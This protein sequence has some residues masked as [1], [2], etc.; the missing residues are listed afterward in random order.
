MPDDPTDGQR[1]RSPGDRYGPF[2]HVHQV[3]P[4]LHVADASGAHTLHARDA[5]RSAGFE[6]E[7]FVDQVDAPLRKEVK[8]FAELDQFVVPD[9]TA[10]IYQLAVGST[11]V[12]SLLVR[13]EPLLLNYHNLTPASFF[14]K[15]APNWLDAVALGRS[16]L[17]RLAKRTSHAIAVSKFNE[18]DLRAAGFLSTSVVPPFVDVG[19]E[20]VSKA[21]PTNTDGDRSSRSG[22]G[23]TW[24]FVG[25]LLPHKAAHD[26]VRGLA[27]YREAYDPSA[28]LVLVGGHPVPSY[29]DAVRDYAGSLGLKDAVCMAGATSSEAL[30]EA[31]ASA[32]VFVCLS[33]HEG[34]C[35]PLLEAMNNGVPVVAYRAGAVPDTLGSAGILLH[36][37]TGPTVASAVHRVLTD[38]RLRENIV[39]AGRRRLHAFD[40]VHT[41]ERF[42]DEVRRALHRVAMERPGGSGTR[43]RPRRTFTAPESAGLM[44]SG[45]VTTRVTAQLHASAP[46]AQLHRTAGPEPVR[47]I[48]QLVPMLVPGDATSDHAI[49]L[50]RLAHDMGLDSEIFATAIHDDLRDESF[51]VHELPDRRLPA[52]SFI[53]QMSSGSPMVDLAR[54]RLE[55]LAVNYHNLTPSS[56]YERWEP[57]IAA[58][59]RW[60]RRQIG[61]L[62]GRASLAICDSSYNAREL[63]SNG[64]RS[65]VVCPVLVDMGRF[66]SVERSAQTAHREPDGRAKW[67][68][69]GRIA[70]HKGQHRLVE[71][72]A[73]YVKLYGDGARLDLI[74]R[75]GSLH[76]AEAVRKC[77]DELGVGDLVTIVGDLD[78]LALGDYYRDADVFVSA[79]VHEGFCVP[80]LEAMHHGVPVVALSAAAVPET[81]GGAAL[82]VDSSDPAV[83]ATAVRSVIGDER[84]RVRLVADGRARAQQL[85]LE[86]SRA[87]MRR[88]LEGWIEGRPMARP[89]ERPTER[90]VD[91]AASAQRVAQ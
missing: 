8:N 76:Y 41:K 79:S 15:W 31:Y 34:F 89:I 82:L 5:L 43:E 18:R 29:A 42:A 30:S 50:R 24:L 38:D 65:T 33:E 61:N 51:L 48:H 45:S 3:L 44:T 57:A 80:I 19:P 2:T 23:A 88:A 60:A 14:W 47:A 85:S 17:H 90:T 49:Q 21:E 7:I 72:L 11:L 84:L 1:D 25:K 53:Y 67:L 9:S 63:D 81:A 68:F 59:Q 12:N 39:G 20:V 35:F 37:K 77:A 4:A 27:A 40:L 66:G 54:E 55:P 75:P 28:R 58:E 86:R 16:Q 74:G 62:S 10:L 46:L 70:P 69:V 87:T 13:E 6:S 78:D 52:T 22:T 56:A 36:D 73:T 83:L 32:D 91:S 64:Y 71:A 26:L